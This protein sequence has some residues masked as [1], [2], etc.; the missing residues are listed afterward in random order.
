MS[1]T[2][3]VGTI[4]IASSSL[5][6]VTW[7]PVADELTHQG[8]DVV[9]Y[10][11]DKVAAGEMALDIHVDGD[12][13]LRV[14]LGGRQLDL[15]AILAAW[16]RRPNAFARDQLDWARQLSLDQERRNMQTALWSAIPGKVWLSAPE[17]IRRAEN[18]IGQLLAAREVGFAI[19]Q[20]VVSNRWFTINSLLPEDIIL[21]M[22][23]GALYSGSTSDE[24][25]VLPTTRLTNDPTT[26]PVDSRP[27][28]GYW[29]PYV[30]KGKEWRITVVGDKFFDAAIYTSDDAKTDWRMKQF[31]PTKVAFKAE[32]FPDVQHQ[33]C[34]AFLGN[35]GLRFGAFD[36]IET[37]DGEIVFLECNPNGQYGWLEEQL[38][39]PISKALAAELAHIATKT[40]SAK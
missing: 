25:L 28:P 8:Y 15:E 13:G 23:V 6:E 3:E 31:D 37:P 40:R 36:F 20:T 29:Q 21:K 34:L 26:L 32:R 5:D 17:Q 19:P 11:A 7:K 16:W 35:I 14:W 1:K 22:S 12:T 10:E 9:A 2:P 24:L 18:K 39:L 30:S 27:F 38:G 4:L 33:R